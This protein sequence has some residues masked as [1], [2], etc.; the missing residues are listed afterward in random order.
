M[1]LSSVPTPSVLPGLLV[2]PVQREKN[3][4]CMAGW[5]VLMSSPG[6]HQID[7]ITKI[8]INIMVY[9]FLSLAL[10]NSPVVAWIAGQDLATLKQKWFLT[11]QTAPKLSRLFYA[12]DFYNLM[13]RQKHVFHSVHG[14]SWNS[15]VAFLQLCVTQLTWWLHVVPFPL[16]ITYRV[17]SDQKQMF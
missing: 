15:T 8:T 6:Q 3:L 2:R 4:P 11:F 12:Y 1:S 10:S 16:R 17:L 5:R 7:K 13:Q 14:K 9:L